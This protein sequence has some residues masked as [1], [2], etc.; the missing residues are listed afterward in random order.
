MTGRWAASGR[1]ILRSARNC[2]LAPITEPRPDHTHTTDDR[3]A[4]VDQ[5]YETTSDSGALQPPTV[6]ILKEYAQQHY[7]AEVAALT[8]SDSKADWMLTLNAAVIGTGLLQLDLLKQNGFSALAFA[9]SSAAALTGIWLCIRV[10]MPGI[11]PAPM[12]VRH[13]VDTALDRESRLQGNRLSSPA[14][15]H[16]LQ[17]LLTR[18]YV[19]AIVGLQLLTGW[20]SRQIQA[21]KYY[22][23]LATAIL[24]C[25]AVLAVIFPVGGTAG[26]DAAGVPA[27]TQAAGPAR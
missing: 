27:S 1:R 18:S 15:D 16:Q 2:W 25:A 8:L 19:T 11:T 4:D 24:C 3:Q 10:K 23:M 7:D 9:L 5:W 14:V 17:F 13:L 26:D 6:Q 20:K 21:A 12:R 22:L